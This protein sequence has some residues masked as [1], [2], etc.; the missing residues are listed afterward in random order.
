MK[1]LMP[2][3]ILMGEFSDE[4]TL[5]QYN[6]DEYK[7]ILNACKNGKLKQFERGLSKHDEQFLK[8]GIYLVLEKLKNVVHRNFVMN[9]YLTNESNHIIKLDNCVEEFKKTNEDEKDDSDMDEDSDDELSVS[10]IECMLAGLIYKGFIKGY[11]SHE[12]SVL[13]LSKKEPF[14]PLKNVIEKNGSNI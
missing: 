9:I 2:I 13:V 6:I 10:G 12:K 5:K 1:Y 8:S 14:P 11:I 3:N 4:A 7:E